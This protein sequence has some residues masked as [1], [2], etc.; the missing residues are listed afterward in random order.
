MNIVL[1]SPRLREDVGDLSSEISLRE[2]IVWSSPPGPW[3]KIRSIL[4]SAVL[5]NANRNFNSKSAKEREAQ[6]VDKQ[7][8][9]FFYT[10]NFWKLSRGGGRK[11]IEEHES[12]N[13]N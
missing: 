2:T 5:M 7:V 9:S 1:F 13:I 8:H 4:D 3:I 10:V 11:G 12:N 6:S